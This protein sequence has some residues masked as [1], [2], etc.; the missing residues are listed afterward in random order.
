MAYKDKATRIA[1]SKEYYISNRTRIRA[2][3]KEYYD[4][5]AETRRQQSRD[6]YEA[7]KPEVL[8][9]GRIRQKVYYKNNKEARSRYNI[10]LWQRLKQET[11]SA[12]GGAVCVRCGFKDIRALQIDHLNGGGMKH[13]KSFSSNKTYLR[14]VRENSS[15]FQVLCANCNWIKV[16]ENREL[17]GKN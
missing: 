2:K 10:G 3:H 5:T 4:K 14:Y 7:N 13:M 9:K 16:S 6:Y 11:F 12:L 17:Y 1:K 8:R 15:L